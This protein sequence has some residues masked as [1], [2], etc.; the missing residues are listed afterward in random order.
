MTTYRV[1]YTVEYEG[2]NSVEFGSLDEV[3]KFID[4]NIRSYD[5]VIIIEMGQF[6]D[7]YELMQR[8]KDKK[9]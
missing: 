5:D 6:V 1:T 4:E 2:E 7:V 8:Y 3:A 9:K